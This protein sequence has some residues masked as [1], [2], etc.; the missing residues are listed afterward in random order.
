MKTWK[1]GGFLGGPVVKTGPLTAKGPGVIPGQG[2][3]IPKYV[4][5]GKKKKK[6]DCQ[7]SFFKK[8]K[9]ALKFYN[10]ISENQSKGK[11]RGL[12]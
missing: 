4:P 6:G 9:I 12:P 11:I 1:N 8:W 5:H 3:K 7:Y 2:T 10:I